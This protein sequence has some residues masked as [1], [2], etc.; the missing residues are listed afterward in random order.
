[1]RKSRIQRLF[2]TSDSTLHARMRGLPA[3]MRNLT[4]RHCP[5]E[6]REVSKILYNPGIKHASSQVRLAPLQQLQHVV[7]GVFLRRPPAAE[8]SLRSLHSV[9]R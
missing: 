1:M 5:N 8:G 7:F 3:C 4:Y 9:R 6:L 2:V